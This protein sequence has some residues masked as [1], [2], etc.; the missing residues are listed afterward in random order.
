MTGEKKDFPLLSGKDSKG[1]QRDYQIWA[2]KNEDGSATIKKRWGLYGMKQQENSRV[3]SKGK[4]IGRAN[5]TTPFQQACLEA[6][7]S[8]K[9]KC[10]SGYFDGSKKTS[11]DTEVKLPML[12]HPYIKRKHHIKWPAFCQPKLDGMRVLAF[13]TADGLI[14]YKSRRGK[15]IHTLHHLTKK[16]NTYMKDGEIFDGEIYIHGATFQ[17]IISLAKNKK[18][19]TER[20]EFWVFDIVELELTNHERNSLLLS[21]G[22]PLHDTDKAASGGICLVDTTLIQ[23]E[24][25]MFAQHTAYVALGFEG[26]IIRNQCGLYK[27]KH[28]SADLQKYKEFLDEEFKIIDTISDIDGGIIYTCETLSEKSFNV[29]PRGTLETR[30]E[31]YK[32]CENYEGKRLTVRYQNLSPTGVPI[33]PVGIVVRDYE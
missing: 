2:E 23:K 9:L 21:R 6:E 3:V 22:L 17:E 26:L 8:W 19:D 7:A 11:G 30:R 27:L 29:R 5:E 33:F 18:K 16:L 25:R 15:E 12:A 32:Y 13:K 20:L 24:G 14:Q 1:N 28:R 31:A 10:D 4:N